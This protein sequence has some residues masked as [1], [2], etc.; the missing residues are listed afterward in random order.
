MF[1]IRRL[2][3]GFL[4]SSTQQILDR[5]AASTQDSLD[6]LRKMNPEIISS[7]PEV[8]KASELI[9]EA[10]NSKHLLSGLHDVTSHRGDEVDV[11]LR[12]VSSDLSQFMA[13][14]VAQNLDLMLKT[15]DKQC[16]SVINES[17][18]RAN[19]SSKIA[20]NPDFVSTLINDQVG[21]EVH[22]KINEINL[23]MAN[24]ISDRVIDEVIDSLTNS[25]R[26]LNAEVGSSKK[27]RSL[28]PDVL[29]NRSVSVSESLEQESISHG[30]DVASQ[31]SESS[32][33]STPQTSKR[34]SIQ[35]RKLRPNA[36]ASLEEA[37]PDLVMTSTPNTSSLNGSTSSE[38]VDTVPELPSATALTHLGKARPKRPKKHAPTRGTVIARPSEDSSFDEGM[39]KFYTSSA[40]NSFSPGI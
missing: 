21:Q 15:A 4:L 6:A 16:P 13:A 2:T 37:S 20:L 35:G 26:I 8:S 9:K 18:L 7:S 30:S 19:L 5:L 24:H 40:N 32:P 23:I 34:K 11:K 38:V 25:G 39:E 3:Q 1:D 22:N 31:K 29:K 33:I 17:K 36:Q 12:Q 10:E 28:T 14:H 27:K